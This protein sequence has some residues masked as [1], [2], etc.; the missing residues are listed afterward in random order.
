MND[1]PGVRRRNNQYVPRLLV[2]T[3][4]LPRAMRRLAVGKTCLWRRLLSSGRASESKR[5]FQERTA[6][7]IKFYKRM[8]LGGITLMLGST[9]FAI[10]ANQTQIDLIKQEKE[11]KKDNQAI[12]SSVE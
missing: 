9:V 2:A 1:L 12:G 4:L 10:Y 3:Q 7:E 11:E 8:G 6:R 5:E